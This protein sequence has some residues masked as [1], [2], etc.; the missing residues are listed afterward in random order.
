MTWHDWHTCIRKNPSITF[1]TSSLACNTPGS[2]KMGVGF[3]HL[4]FFWLAGF[5]SVPHPFPLQALL[6]QEKASGH[7]ICRI[8]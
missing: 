5:H 7:H 6:L 1:A 2:A 8:P 3:L 4:F